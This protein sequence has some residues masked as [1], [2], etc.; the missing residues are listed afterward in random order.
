MVTGQVLK[1]ALAQIPTLTLS[2][3]F[4]NHKNLTASKSCFPLKRSAIFMFARLNFP[5]GMVGSYIYNLNDKWAECF[6]SCEGKVALSCFLS[7]L[8]S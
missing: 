5:K 7:F 1:S 2:N 4:L 8:S 3:I 6:Q